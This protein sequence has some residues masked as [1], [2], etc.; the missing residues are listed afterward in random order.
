MQVTFKHAFWLFST[1][2]MGLALAC[3]AG[4]AD[5]GASETSSGTENG[6]DQ[7]QE[8]VVTAQKRSEALLSTAAPVTAVQAGDLALQEANKIADYAA[9]VPGLNLITSQPGQSVVI[10]RGVNTGFGASI[11]ATTATYLDEVPYGSSTASAYGS[12]ATLDL[13]PSTLKSIE[14]LRGPQG[15][16]YGASSLGGL[17]KYVTRPPGLDDYSGRVEVDGNS[18]DGGGQG[19]GYRA[20]LDGPLVKDKLGITVSA[21]NRLDPGYIDDPHRHEKNVNSSKADGGRVALLWQPTDNFSAELSALVQDSYT[22]STSMVDL[23]ANMVPIYGKYQQV[24]YG[25]ENWDFRNRQYSLTA[26]YDLGWADITSVS[27]YATRKATWDIDESVK[28]GPLISSPAFLNIPNLGLFDNVTLDNYKTTQEVRLSSPDGQRLE[29]LGGLFFTHEHS[30]KPEALQQPIS[31]ATDLP[32]PQAFVPGGVYTDILHDSYTEYAGYADLTYHITPDFKI[33]G[34]V[35]FSDDLERAVTPYS[36]LLN[37]PPAVSIGDSHS[38]PVT[39]LVSPSY[40]IDDRDMVYA[41]IASGFRPGGPTGVL[42]NQLVAGAPMTYRPDSLLNYEV[43]Y[44]ASF[45]AQRMTIDVSAFDIEW[46]NIQVLTVINGFN[47]TGNGAN[48]RS[49]GLEFAWTWKPITGLSL[50]ANGAY[51]DAHLTADAPGIGGKSGDALPNV[52]KFAANLGADYNFPIDSDVGGFVGGNVQYQGNRYADF[53]KGLP[54]GTSRFSMPDYE[55]VNLH[56]GVTRGGL[57]I[58]AYAKNLSN[59]YAYS[60]IVSEVAN[61]Y[62]PPLGAALIQP[63]TFG[64]S[65]SDD[66]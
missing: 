10:M 33:L 2:A 12:I 6:Q 58:E 59:S 32:V 17:I 22:P 1:T 28:F 57:N 11:P 49:D 8:V 9:T 34:G 64:I 19:Y 36:G 56:A 30:I 51:T 15:T 5:L 47:V 43:G 54:A 3:S 53:V 39:F 4:A 20:M 38:E 37:G 62:G 42:S 63:R 29:W 13:D 48:A 23:N 21:F 65:I 45:P 60:R 35:R 55:T 26:I 52:P 25:N 41:R 46:S 44:K 7:L 14:V 18:V 50:S 61:G 24:R 16:L 40:N 27:S 31:L 66:F